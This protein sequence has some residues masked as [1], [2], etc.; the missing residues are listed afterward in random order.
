MYDNNMH[1]ER[2]MTVSSY[3]CPYLQC[4]IMS[5]K[6]HRTFVRNYEYNLSSY[7]YYQYN[8]MYVWNYVSS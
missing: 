6:Y 1:G 4:V 8:C 7:E 3:V 5:N 2:I